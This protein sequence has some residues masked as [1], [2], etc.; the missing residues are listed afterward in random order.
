MSIY[1]QFLKKIQFKIISVLSFSN[2]MYI[3]FY[4]IL[5]LFQLT[6]MLLLDLVFVNDNNSVFSTNT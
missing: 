4:F 6:K 5:S 1:F 3:L 2:N